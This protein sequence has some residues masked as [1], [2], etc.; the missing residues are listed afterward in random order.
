M[1]SLVHPHAA[2][3]AL[4]VWKSIAKVF[5][6]EREGRTADFALLG[7]MENRRWFSFVC[8]DEEQTLTRVEFVNRTVL[9]V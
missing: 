4:S 6:S 1:D 2:M 5:P 7:K 9:S 8:F 3:G